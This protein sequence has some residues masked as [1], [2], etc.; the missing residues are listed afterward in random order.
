MQVVIDLNVDLREK[1]L[2]VLLC[3]FDGQGT[4]VSC[5]W[6]GWLGQWGMDWQWQSEHVALVMHQN[7]WKDSSRG[8]VAAL[9]Q[10]ASD[11]MTWLEDPPPWLRRACCFASVIVWTENK[12]VTT[13]DRFICFILTVKQSA[14]LAA[15]VWRAATKKGCQLFW[16]KSAPP[17]KILATLLTLGDLAW[18]FS[19]PKM[20]W[21]LYCAGAATAAE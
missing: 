2:L 8:T 14:V 17:E 5:K 10:D 13:S 12:N 19:D 16:G 1:S 4:T 7:V 3:L 9:H 15:C 21:L 20:T 6:W 18:G 11:Q